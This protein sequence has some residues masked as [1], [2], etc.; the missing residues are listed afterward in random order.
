MKFRAIVIVA[1][2]V[3][4]AA[5]TVSKMPVL[6]NDNAFSK[7]VSGTAAC[8]TNWASLYTTPYVAFY[9]NAYVHTATEGD[10]ARF[11]IT[12]EIGIG[13]NKLVYG[14]LD[15]VKTACIG[16]AVDTMRSA[17][18]CFGFEFYPPLASRVRFIITGITGNSEST[19]VDSLGLWGD[20]PNY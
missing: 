13:D 14:F 17:A 12:Y 9:C 11:D 10:S 3:G 4:A 20:T 15:T 7:R 6:F 18:K 19:Y 16:T 5:A 1:L 2:L 8:T